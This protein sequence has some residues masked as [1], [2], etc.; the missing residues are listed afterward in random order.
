MKD[1]FLLKHVKRHKEGFVSLKLISSFRK[2]KSVTKDYRHVVA[3]LRD[4][5]ELEIN[6]EGTKVRR[7]L[8]LPAH[9]EAFASRTV[10]AFHLPMENPTVEQ[11]SQLFSPCGEI[12]LV[13]ILRPG[14]N[15]P[16]DVRKFLSKHPELSNNTCAVVEFERQEG[17]LNACRSLDDSSNWRSGMRVSLMARGAAASKK[18]QTT[19][20]T[21]DKASN[22][23]GTAHL[24]Q[25]GLDMSLSN[26]NA[27]VQVS[28]YSSHRSNDY[29]LA[30]LLG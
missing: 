3:A 16:S 4:S 27:R 7:H 5:S 30:V 15:L 9:D 11:I 21:G 17:A 2:V 19:G 13:R 26:A 23:N 10:I 22:Q 12:A 8:P 25:D 24:L 18:E 28:K 20:E 14:K 29:Q 1:A 6:A